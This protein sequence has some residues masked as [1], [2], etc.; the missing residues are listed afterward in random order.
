MRERSNLTPAQRVFQTSVDIAFMCG[1]ADWGTGNSETDYKL[2]T[3]WAELVQ[4]ARQVDTEGHV[5][6]AG[7]EYY[8]HIWNV[9]S[10]KRQER[11]PS[12]NVLTIP[13]DPEGENDHRA[14]WA[15]EALEA[16][17]AQTGTE[18]G[19][20]VADLICDLH[21][22][23]DRNNMNFQQQVGRAKG[24]YEDETYDDNEGE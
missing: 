16:F 5:T 4:S 12:A 9:V 13:P 21:H 15:G 2:F 18:Q 8:T 20:S 19:D 17:R 7:R 22:W 23:C 3:E 24:M 10:Q 1:G 11:D 6:Y 14:E